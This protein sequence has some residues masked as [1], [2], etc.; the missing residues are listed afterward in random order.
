MDVD[1]GS[2]GLD[3][4]ST[5]TDFCEKSRMR[6]KRRGF[7]IFA[8]SAQILC[9]LGLFSGFRGNGEHCVTTLPA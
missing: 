3:S 1:L 4:L 9:N 2:L 7:E 5:S 8:E 6:L